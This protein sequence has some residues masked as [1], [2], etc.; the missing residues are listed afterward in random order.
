[1][2]WPNFLKGVALLL[3]DPNGLEL[4]PMLGNLNEYNWIGSCKGQLIKVENS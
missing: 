3:S 1:L 2:Q 4:V